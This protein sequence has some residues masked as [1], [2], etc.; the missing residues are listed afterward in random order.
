MAIIWLTNRRMAHF[1]WES[2]RGTARHPEYRFVDRNRFLE[3]GQKS[4]LFES[5]LSGPGHAN[6]VTFPPQLPAS[7]RNAGG[8][9]SCALMSRWFW[10]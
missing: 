7:S 8:W 9:R 1:H 5:P 2:N 10:P 3:F 4:G 6:H